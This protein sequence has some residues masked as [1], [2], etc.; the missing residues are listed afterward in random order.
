M[1]YWSSGFTGQLFA[2]YAA[3]AVTVRI[4]TSLRRSLMRCVVNVPAAVGTLRVDEPVGLYTPAGCGGGGPA[5]VRTGGEPDA[6]E[7]PGHGAPSPTPRGCP[8][9]R[10][11]AG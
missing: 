10:G 11:G 9:G 8:P 1:A 2:Q 4:V 5:G 7:A 6:P 3:F